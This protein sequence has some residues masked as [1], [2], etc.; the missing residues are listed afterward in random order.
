VSRHPTQS[1]SVDDE[2][3]HRGVAKKQI[4]VECVLEV[5]EVALRSL[6]I[7]LTGLYMWR[8]T[9]CTV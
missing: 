2:I 5:A 6:E 4:V 9:C 7:G 8:H 1:V 3:G